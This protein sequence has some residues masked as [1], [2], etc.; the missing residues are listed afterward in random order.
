MPLP[1][2]V[3]LRDVLDALDRAHPRQH[4]VDG[5]QPDPGQLEQRLARLADGRARE[6]GVAA[7]AGNAEIRVQSLALAPGEADG[8]PREH[9]PERLRD[10]QRQRRDQP[11][12][13]QSGGGIASAAA[14]GP[15]RFPHQASASAQIFLA[16][17]KA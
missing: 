7:V 17:A 5:P 3:R 4:L 10:E 16:Q 9:G 2:R 14:T 8:D 6:R 1:R 15:G 11:R 13:K 12:A